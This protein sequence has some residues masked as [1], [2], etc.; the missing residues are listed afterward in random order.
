M[1]HFVKHSTIF[2][3][4]KH[5]MIIISILNFSS[6]LDDLADVLAL[7][8][9]RIHGALR[10]K[11][12]SR[13]SLAQFINFRIQSI[14]MV[15]CMRKKTHTSS[16]LIFIPTREKVVLFAVWPSSLLLHILSP[17]PSL[18]AP[19]RF[20]FYEN[21]PREAKKIWNGKKNS[22]RKF[23]HWTA[24]KKLACIGTSASSFWYTWRYIVQQWKK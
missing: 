9:G 5:L 16:N 20:S 3:F 22:T 6:R 8:F 2:T 23:V 13:K 7:M 14:T 24:R 11:S 1:F 21:S 17:G 19:G 4:N 12:S 15:D 18:S 10:R